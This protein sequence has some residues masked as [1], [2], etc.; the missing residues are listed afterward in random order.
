MKIRVAVCLL[1]LALS[2]GPLTA[3]GADGVASVFGNEILRSDLG[4][5]K[6]EP[7]QVV[8]F[9]DLIWERVARHYVAERGLA[10]TDKAISLNPDYAEALTY[11]NIL[12]RMQANTETDRAKQDALIKEADEIR[13]KDMELNKRKASGKS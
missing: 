7:V 13:N 8:R 5:E 6:D 2:V 10:A 9:R 3:S 4:P 1:L 12:L 11:K